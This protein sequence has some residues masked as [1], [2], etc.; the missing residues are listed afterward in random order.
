MY[1]HFHKNIY[2]S[3]TSFNKRNFFKPKDTLSDLKLKPRF[4]KYLK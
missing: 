1:K 4:I 2:M 3:K